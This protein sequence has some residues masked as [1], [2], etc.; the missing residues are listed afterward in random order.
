MFKL[1]RYRQK[2]ECQRGFGQTVNLKLEKEACKDP[3]KRKEIQK[4][5]NK[6][7]KQIKK[8]VKKQRE[9][10]IIENIE[11]VEKLKDDSRRMFAAIREINKKK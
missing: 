4:Q 1:R 7:L 6:V 11:N 8:E 2:R 9:N 3:A 10:E 5:R